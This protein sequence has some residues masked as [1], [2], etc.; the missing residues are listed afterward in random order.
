M[1]GRVGGRRYQYM[2]RR[3]LEYKRELYEE[4]RRLTLE[5]F[6]ER[7]DDL[8]APSLRVRSHLL[9]EGDFDSLQAL[10]AMEAELRTDAKAGPLRGDELAVEARLVGDRAPLRFRRDGDR[11]V[12]LPPDGVA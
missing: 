5:R 2:P 1:L 11:L 4:V 3:D 9:R 8:L 6:D 12:W 7:F 10:A